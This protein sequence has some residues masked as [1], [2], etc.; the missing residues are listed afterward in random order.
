LLPIVPLSG[1]ALTVF[2]RSAQKPDFAKWFNERFTQRRDSFPTEKF[3]FLPVL[4]AVPES[5]LPGWVQNCMQPKT[6]LSTLRYQEAFRC[7]KCHSENGIMPPL[8]LPFGPALEINS[9]TGLTG[10]GQQVRWEKRVHREL[11]V[12]KKYD[13]AAVV[14]QH[15]I[16]EAHM[17]PDFEGLLSR[18]ERTRIYSCLMTDY[19]GSLYPGVAAPYKKKEGR[20][21]R[22]LLSPKCQ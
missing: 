5:E 18:E 9:E 22:A 15:Y 3:S 21:L 16:Q 17:P 14:P 8:M 7:A 2:S 19:F 6:P 11:G 4:G 12:D 1:T 10:H 13:P 20:F